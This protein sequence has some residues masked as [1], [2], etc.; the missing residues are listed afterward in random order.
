MSTFILVSIFSVVVCAKYSNT[1]QAL[2]VP[3]SIFVNGQ[4]LDSSIPVISHENSTYL[5]IRTL[6]NVLGAEIE[7]DSVNRK[8]EIL[9]KKSEV[10]IQVESGYQG[11]EG[12][13]GKSIDF[14]IPL[15]TAVMLAEEAFQQAFGDEFMK[16]TYVSNV[17][18]VDNEKYFSVTRIKKDGPVVGGCWSAIIRKSDGK[19]MR[20]E[21]GE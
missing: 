6:C 8:I 19:I 18:E 5:P 3:F 12:W 7:W 14:Q 1:I 9:T 20:I 17:S 10:D 2:K 4:Q 21:T 15:Q 16:S 11:I 13:V